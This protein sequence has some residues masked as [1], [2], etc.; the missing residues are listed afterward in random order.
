MNIATETANARGRLSGEPV[1]S[2]PLA[3][4]PFGATPHFASR[5]DGLGGTLLSENP[6]YVFLTLNVAPALGA[7]KFDIQLHDL[8]ATTGTLVL[9]VLATSV[10]P[11]AGSVPVLTSTF[12]LAD[13]PAKGG[14]AHVEFFARRNMFYALEASIDDDSDARADAISILLDRRDDSDGANARFL[15]DRGEG[16][17]AGVLRSRVCA[18]PTM[19]STRAP[20]LAQPISQVMTTGQ[21][22]EAAFSDWMIEL[23][24]PAESDPARWAD[25]YIL[26][27]LRHY[28]AV[29]AGATALGI[30]PA[31]SALPAY[32]AG[33]DCTILAATVHSDIVSDTD[34]GIALEGLV[35]SDLCPMDRFEQAVHTTVFERTAMPPG[36]RNFDF[37]WVNE[38]GDF[39]IDYGVIESFMIDVM[40]RLRVGGIVVYIL[41]YVASS[42]IGGGAKRA[43][44]SRIEIERLAL[45]LVSYGHEVGQLAFGSNSASPAPNGLF[46]LIARRSQ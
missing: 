11:G 20:R 4:D 46:G 19:V 8:Y 39:G 29:S 15:S 45:S 33:R 12:L 42:Q 9:R 13:L 31:Q 21:F 17:A 26:Q 16:R 37:I 14:K 35:H 25:A 18:T 2:D 22:S 3:I 5:L 36:L 34:P 41:P 23:R 1:R 38:G 7:V 10:F 24:Q 30:G 40:G 44:F 28:D 27:T 32:L 6:G 43:G